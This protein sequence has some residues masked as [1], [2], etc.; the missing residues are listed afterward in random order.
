[1]KVTS[2][3][4]NE[5]SGA[6]AGAGPASQRKTQEVTA[7]G[8]KQAAD[9]KAQQEAEAK[10]HLIQWQLVEEDEDHEIEAESFKHYTGILGRQQQAEESSRNL[11]EGFESSMI[12]GCCPRMKSLASNL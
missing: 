4:C 5:H 8:R 10:S 3:G 9:D 1:M 6:V 7:A 12:L 2:T 11:G